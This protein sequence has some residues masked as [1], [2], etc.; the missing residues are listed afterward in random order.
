MEYPVISNWVTFSKA[1]RGGYY[2][3][4]EAF[5]GKY[6]M[7]EETFAFF[8]KLDGETDPYTI[9]PSYDPNRIQALLEVL[10]EELLIRNSRILYKSLGNILITLWPVE[11]SSM[12]KKVSVIADRLLSLLWLPIFTTGVLYMIYHSDDVRGSDNILLGIFFGLITALV[13]HEMGHA[14][15]CL[16][17]GGKVYEF[18]VGFD[19]FLPC[20]Y[21]LLNMNDIKSR[22]KRAHVNAAG[23]EMNL[24]L[25]GVFLYLSCFLPHAGGLMFFAAI[26]NALIALLNLLFVKGIDGMGVI[27]EFLGCSDLFSYAKDVIFDRKKRRK[28]YRDGLNGVVTLSGCYIALV[29]Q[30]GLPLLIALN[31]A[32]LII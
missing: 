30:I 31:I 2:V 9:Q 7:S 15:A 17:Y 19:T 6:H 23:I 29:L 11:R 8:R 10:E 28:L 4:D 20:A 22:R 1:E 12:Q 27:S 21:V 13:L 24:L 14:A 18:G 3:F 25:T 5:D 26:Q 16:H 32:F